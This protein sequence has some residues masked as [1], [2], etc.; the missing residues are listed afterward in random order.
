MVD[1]SHSQTFD[2]PHCG[3]EVSLDARRCHVCGASDESGW[4]ETDGHDALG[5]Y[6]SD[7]EFDYDD[8]IARE[9][10]TDGKRPRAET[11]DLQFRLV[12]LAVVISL[13]LPLILAYLW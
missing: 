5:G 4:E 11:R 12:I 13:L 9:F 7:D 1:S 10:G 6:G 8:F 3:E 2:C